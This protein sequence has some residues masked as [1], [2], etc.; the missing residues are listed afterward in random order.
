MRIGVS[1]SS[2]VQE[3]VRACQGVDRTN[4]KVGRSFGV[5]A[6]ELTRP[7]GQQRTIVCAQD[8]LEGNG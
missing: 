7:S 2:Y 3:N 4:L 1:L 6:S 5:G 8:H